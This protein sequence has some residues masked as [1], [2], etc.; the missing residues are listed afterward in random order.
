M[1]N[2]WLQTIM[3]LSARHHRL[4]H[5]WGLWAELRCRQVYQGTGRACRSYWTGFYVGGQVGYGRG[6]FGPDTHPLAVAGRVLS[7]QHHRPD[8]RLSGGYNF[9]LPNNLVLA[10]RSMFIPTRSS[11]D[12]YRPRSTP[13]STT[14]PRPAAASDTHSERCCPTSQ[15]ASLGP[16]P[17]R[18]QR[19][20]W[21]RVIRARTCTARLDRRRW[22]RICRRTRWSAK[23]EYGYI[24]LTRRTH[25]LADVPLPDV[26]IA[27][28]PIS[29][30]LV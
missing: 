7:P 15:A 1:G 9:Q 17:R 13:P 19:C 11:S 24:D 20:R 29:V 2:L 16:G 26:A 4:V 22:R 3:E 28:E 23:L 12:S 5:P 10:P 8:R 18:R 27:P 14:L 21:Q 25:G 6:S 30:S